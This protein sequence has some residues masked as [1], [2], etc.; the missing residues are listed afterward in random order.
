MDCNAEFNAAA[1]QAHNTYRA[2]HHAPPL[3]LN[4]TL[5]DFATGYCTKLATEVKTLVY[6]GVQD[7]GENL[8]WYSSTM[9]SCAEF[10]TKLTKFWYSEVSKYSFS[11]PVLSTSK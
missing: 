6:S 9:K 1:L 3:V 8:G 7:Y 11:N 2:L 10:A 4:Q 5:I